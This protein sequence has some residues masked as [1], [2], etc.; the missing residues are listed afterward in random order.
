[1]SINGPLGRSVDDLIILQKFLM[2]EIFMENDFNIPTLPFND[3]IVN[4]YAN[5]QGLRIG[6]L[7]YDGLF[8]PCAPSIE[9]I[10]K[11]V[12]LLKK[13]GH[14]LIEIDSKYI[15][16]LI[17][18]YGRIVFH[19]GD[20]L[21]EIL[22]GEPPLSQYETANLT[23]IIPECIKPLVCYL[24]KKFGLKREALFTEYAGNKSM[25][26]F[27]TGCLK[28]AIACNENMEMWKSLNLDWMI[29]PATGLPPLKH[30]QGGDLSLSC[31]YTACFNILDY[32][33]GVI[34][35]VLRVTEE[36][37]KVPYNDEKYKDDDLVMKARETLEG[38]NS[39]KTCK[40]KEGARGM[41]IWIQVATM[42]G[43][44][45]KWLGIMKQIDKIIHQ[46]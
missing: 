35:N 39:W 31:F 18:G 24:L 30:G 3:N 36:H 32:P 11:S 12:D 27:T 37:L 33:A 10:D 13:A 16:S 20:H 28:K 5:K 4:E 40:C 44:E 41:P 14:E 21:A 8:Y 9:A 42:V 26:S 46:N 23:N 29:V 43:E 45:E 25:R 22:R 17:E 38:S 2:S 19:G 34:P 1:M 7:T 15:E 6:Y